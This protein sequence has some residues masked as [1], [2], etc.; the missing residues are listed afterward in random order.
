M[1]YCRREAAVVPVLTSDGLLAAVLIFRLLQYLRGRGRVLESREHICTVA[2]EIC[3][4][5]RTWVGL[6]THQALPQDAI[7]LRPVQQIL[8]REVEPLGGRRPI[9]SIMSRLWDT[10]PRSGRR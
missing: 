4:G 1:H 10:Q 3:S 5:R 7:V 2:A 8:R 6:V 9:R